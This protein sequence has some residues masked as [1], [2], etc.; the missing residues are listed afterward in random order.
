VTETKTG[1]NIRLSSRLADHLFK[2]SGSK[3]KS[4]SGQHKAVTRTFNRAMRLL[5]DKVEKDND[6][7]SIK[8]N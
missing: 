4:Y 5:L 8:E 2:L 7:K 6:T 1:A 3:A